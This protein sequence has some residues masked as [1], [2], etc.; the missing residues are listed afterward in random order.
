MHSL[1]YDAIKS[2][3]NSSYSTTKDKAEMLQLYKS[4]HYITEE[5][6]N[7]LSELILKEANPSVQQ[8]L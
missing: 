7:E 6:F 1:Y 2:L 3:I 8:S 5:E 4:W